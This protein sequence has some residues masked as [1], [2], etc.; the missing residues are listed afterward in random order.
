MLVNHQLKSPPFCITDTKRTPRQPVLI[1]DRKHMLTNHHLYSVPC[2]IGGPAICNTNFC[3]NT[4]PS[5]RQA[6]LLWQLPSAPLSHPVRGSIPK[7]HVL[8]PIQSLAPPHGGGEI[9]VLGATAENVGFQPL[10]PLDL[11]KHEQGSTTT[12]SVSLQ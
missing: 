7:H 8:K 3:M 11:N 2:Y 1:L 4:A 9:L 10:W 6:S 12:T 5:R